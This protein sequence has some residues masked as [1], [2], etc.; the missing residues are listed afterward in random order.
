MKLLEF[1]MENYEVDNM[2]P[3]L[4]AE[5]EA[6]IEAKF[7]RDDYVEMANVLVLLDNLPKDLLQ[8]FWD[9]I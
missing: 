7:E 8:K 4:R 9:K 1:L 3:E 6:Q 5:L 2:S